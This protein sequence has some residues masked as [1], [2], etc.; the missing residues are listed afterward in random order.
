MKRFIPQLLE[1][2]ALLFVLNLASGCAT[3]RPWEREHLADPTMTFEE[4]EAADDQLVF[5]SREGSA[6]GTGEGGGGCAC[7]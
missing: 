6:G 5:E 2:I 7:K 3:V 1:T 4:E